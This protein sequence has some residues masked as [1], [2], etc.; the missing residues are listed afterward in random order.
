MATTPTNL[1]V[2][3]ESP[4][5]LKFN[6]GKIDEFVTSKDHVYVDRFGDNHRTIAGIT[7]DANQAILNYGY[8]TKDSFEDGSTLSTANECL[9]WK[10]NGEYYRWDGPFPKVVPPDSTPDSAG[11]IG[12]GK[13]IGVGDASL[14]SAINETAKKYTSFIDAINSTIDP[15]IGCV[16]T[17]GRFSVDDGGDGIYVRNGTGTPGDTDGGGYFVSQDG[18]RFE[19][20]STASIATFGGVPGHGYRAALD[21]LKAFVSTRDKVIR[22]NCSTIVSMAFTPEIPAGYWNGFTLDVGDNITIATASD[23][24]VKSPLVK[25]VRPVKFFFTGNS[26]S[27]LLRPS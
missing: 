22:I 17:G 10:S 24:A 21:S 7:Y 12:K 15:V 13:W 6:A 2:P 23:E 18:S 1:S 19:L 8:I 27:Y 16:I 4:R 3:S 14:R 20:I 5:D 9:R 11:G 26:T 25:L